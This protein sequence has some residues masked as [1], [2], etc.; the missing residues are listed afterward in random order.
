MTVARGQ[1]QRE[2]Q[3]GE[4]ARVRLR[5]A[6]TCAEQ[7][8]HVR[9]YRSDNLTLMV[10]CKHSPANDASQSCLRIGG[11]NVKVKPLGKHISGDL[12]VE[13]TT[14]AD[15]DKTLGTAFFFSSRRRHTRLVSDWSSDVC[16][17]D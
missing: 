3:G 6:L 4:G 13:R 11:T 17:S 2:C 8:E 7:A 16:S 9:L 1:S 10:V 15:P 14:K 12:F 5:C